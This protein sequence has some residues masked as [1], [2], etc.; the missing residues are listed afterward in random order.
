MRLRLI[1]RSL[2]GWGYSNKAHV[3]GLNSAH[4]YKEMVLVDFIFEIEYKEKNM[5]FGKNF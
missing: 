4:L 3:G 5:K 2:E 1:T